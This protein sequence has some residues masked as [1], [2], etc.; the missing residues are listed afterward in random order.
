MTEE[1]SPEVLVVEESNE[2]KGVER[3]EEE[4]QEES[5][6]S[7]SLPLSPEQP[8]KRRSVIDLSLGLEEVT[9]VKVKR[10]S[11]DLSLGL[12]YDDGSSTSV[13]SKPHLPAS[14]IK[15]GLERQVSNEHPTGEN[16]DIPPEMLALLQPEGEA[17]EAWEGKAEVEHQR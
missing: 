4:T 14:L 10:G 12:A 9:P 2:E 8:I 15:F 3:Q 1:T 7:P 5:K 17:V 6:S 13:S 11:I 16:I